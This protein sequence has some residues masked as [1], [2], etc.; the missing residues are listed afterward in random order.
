MIMAMTCYANE[1]LEKELL[2][3]GVVYCFLKPFDMEDYKYVFGFGDEWYFVGGIF[4]L[5]ASQRIADPCD[6]V[7]PFRGRKSAS[8]LRYGDCPSARVYDGENVPLH[9]GV[10]GFPLA[11][12]YHI[13]DRLP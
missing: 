13:A 4:I 3:A 6:Y 7:D 8:Y 9:H 10:H 12:L 1:Q 5:P 11:L 2:K